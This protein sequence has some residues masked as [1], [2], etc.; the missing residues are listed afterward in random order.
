MSYNF[1]SHIFRAAK[2]SPRHHAVIATSPQSNLRRQ[3]R[4]SA[5][6]ITSH[7]F[8]ICPGETFKWA[9]LFCDT[10]Q[11]STLP[12]LTWPPAQQQRYCY[13]RSGHV[14]FVLIHI[15]TW[16]SLQPPLLSWTWLY[17]KKGNS[18]RNSTVYRAYGNTVNFSHTSQ[19]HFSAS[20]RLLKPMHAQMLK[21]ATNHA[22]N[23]PFPL[24]HVDFHLTH[25]CLGH[26]THHTKRQL[27]CCMHF[28]TKMQQSPHWL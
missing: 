12:L 11:V 26:S 23:R 24:R 10:L 6:K 19:M 20:L 14:A 2:T 5:D 27:D 3:R 25:E 7:F 28:H 17:R 15:C 13:C 22:R 8:V 18:T 1:L 9:I 4:S 16:I 21:N